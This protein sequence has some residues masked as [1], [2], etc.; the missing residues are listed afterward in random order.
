MG[1]FWI[2][3]YSYISLDGRNR[4][5][6]TD[7]RMLG[8]QCAAAVSALKDLPDAETYLEVRDLC[9]ASIEEPG[10]KYNGFPAFSYAAWKESERVNE[11]IRRAKK[12]ELVDGESTMGDEG[13]RETHYWIYSPGA[14]AA[15][16]D[17]FMRDGIA[18]LGW[19]K[20]GDLHEFK[21]KEDIRSV[22]KGCAGVWRYG[23]TPVQSVNHRPKTVKILGADSGIRDGF[24]TNRADER[25]PH[26]RYRWRW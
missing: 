11:E 24:G 12:S 9:R 17:E 19:N 26:R 21:D 3:P 18:A 4:W 1:L 6:M 14:E 8:D 23:E 22:P 20:I 7:E 2:R 15:K 5:A 25:T 16:W 13:A 10:S